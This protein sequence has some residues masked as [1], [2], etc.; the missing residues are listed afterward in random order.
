MSHKHPGHGDRPAFTA[1]SVKGKNRTQ[2]CKVWDCVL[3]SKL[4][5][6]SNRR[7]ADQAKLTTVA[8][9]ISVFFVVFLAEKSTW[10]SSAVILRHLKAKLAV[11]FIGTES[12]VAP[13][14]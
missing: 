1:E 7:A 3:C 12:S 6:S 14:P 2:E 5:A 9:R 13:E 4:N 11:S 10:H 8:K